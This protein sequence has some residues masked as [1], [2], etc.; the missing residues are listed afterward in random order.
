MRQRGIGLLALALSPALSTHVLGASPLPVT[1]TPS[2]SMLATA[3]A[4]SA[5]ERARR[6][7]DAR[8]KVERNRRCRPSIEKDYAVAVDRCKKNIEPEH[9]DDRKKCFA[10][11]L[12]NYY[13]SLSD[14]PG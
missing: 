14:C 6:A 12:Q 13:K 11:A 3:Q 1:Q 2:E 5:E 7:R 10:G 9:A 8:E 4:S